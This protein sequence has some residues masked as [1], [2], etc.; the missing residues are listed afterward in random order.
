MVSS[1]EVPR[2]PEAG[3]SGSAGGRSRSFLPPR[4]TGT[5]RDA[6]LAMA[7]ACL[8]ATLAL[9]FWWPVVMDSAKHVDPW[10]FVLGLPAWFLGSI[11]LV[12]AFLTVRPSARTP[13]PVRALALIAGA[14]AGLGA[15][16][17]GYVLLMLLMG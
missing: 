10:R 11:A 16:V 1:F 7:C 8:A 4:R 5:R 13:L 3:N 2:Q 6:V 17:T 15:V 12:L 9:P 14:L